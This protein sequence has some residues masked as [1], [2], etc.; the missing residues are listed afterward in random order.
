MSPAES[1]HTRRPGLFQ[2]QG[3][4]DVAAEGDTYPVTL[5]FSEFASGSKAFEPGLVA[6]RNLHAGSLS[7]PTGLG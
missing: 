1:R 4:S 3:R 7:G 2:Y 6:T 5:R